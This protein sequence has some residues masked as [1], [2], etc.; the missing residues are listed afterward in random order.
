MCRYRGDSSWIRIAVLI[1]V[2]QIVVLV[3][4]ESFS[5]ASSRRKCPQSLSSSL[6]MMKNTNTLL[7]NDLQW[8]SKLLDLLKNRSGRGAR[9]TELETQDITATIERLES[10]QAGNNNYNPIAQPHLNGCWKLLYTSSPGTNSPIQR[11]FTSFDQ[12]SIFQTINLKPYN[13]PTASFLEPSLPEVSNTVC[14]GETAR[15]RVTAMASTTE[16]PLVLP[17]KGDGRV[18]GL[19]IFGVSSSAP[20]KVLYY[21]YYFPLHEHRRRLLQSEAAQKYFFTR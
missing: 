21:Y 2:L 7:G 17:R 10:K 1:A 9:L 19:N 5:T 14:F 15:L 16:A 20:P 13:D 12:V 18:F 8:E 6:S 4:V 3:Q 11:T